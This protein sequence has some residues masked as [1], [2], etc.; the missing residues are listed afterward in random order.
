[1]E[2]D[3][4]SVIE[5]L[6]LR[7]LVEFDEDY[8]VYVGRCIDT[9]AVATGATIEEAQALLQDILRNDFRSAIEEGSLKSLFHA[10]APWDAMVRWYEMKAADPDSVKRIPVEVSPGPEKRGAQSELR[11]IGKTREGV[12]AA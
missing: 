4:P 10:P 2:P 6:E 9:G 1:M 12:S 8:G 3:V 11:V 7:V 5:Q